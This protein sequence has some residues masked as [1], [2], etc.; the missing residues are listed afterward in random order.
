VSKSYLCKN[1]KVVAEYM[2]YK[3]NNL[4]GPN[5][6]VTME[7]YRYM[8]AGEKHCCVKRP[9]AGGKPWTHGT[10]RKAPAA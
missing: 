5:D 4:R 2:K 10:S 3:D 7:G 9:A 8:V 1:M 6:S